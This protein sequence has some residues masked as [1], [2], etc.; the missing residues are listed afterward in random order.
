MLLPM[1]SPTIGAL[2]ETQSSKTHLGNSHVAFRPLASP[3]TEKCY[4]CVAHISPWTEGFAIGCYSDGKAHGGV[5]W[6][7]SRAVYE[8]FTTRD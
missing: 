1:S 6:R 5:V 2:L 7:G 8:S 3:S 4:P